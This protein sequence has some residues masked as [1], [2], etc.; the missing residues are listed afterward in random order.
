[1]KLKIRNILCAILMMF[2]VLLISSKSKAAETTVGG[3]TY[4]Y[5]VVNG[6][7]ENVWVSAGKD[8]FTGAIPG[9]IDGYTVVSIGD[10]TNNILGNRDYGHFDMTR[11]YLP[12]LDIVSKIEIPN[13]VTKI[14]KYAFYSV[15][16]R[17]AY[18]IPESV[19]TI[20]DYAFAESHCYDTDM[21]LVIPNSVQTIGDSAFSNRVS[22]E[23]VA[24]A[25][26]RPYDPDSAATGAYLKS[27]ADKLVLGSGL[28]TIGAN[29]FSYQKGLTGELVIPSNVTT[30]GTDAFRKTS[31]S[32]LTFQDRSSNVNVGESAFQSSVLT[33][34]NLKDKVVLDRNVFK[35]CVQLEDVNV[36]NTFTTI[37]E[38]AFTGCNSL[39][40][41]EVNSIIANAN[42]IGKS[43]FSYCDG[44][45][46]EI[47]IP[48]SLSSMDTGVFRE[49]SNLTS[50]KF[51]NSSLVIIPDS[52]FF[53][54]TS[55]SNIT[56]GSNIIGIGENAFEG[57]TSLSTAEVNDILT[58][59][60]SIGE[61]AF[62]GC[63]GI[64]GKINIRAEDVSSYAFSDCKNMTEAEFFY[65]RDTLDLGGGTFNNCESLV[66]VIFPEDKKIDIGSSS[67]FNNCKSLT[68]EKVKYIL[69]NT[70]GSVGNSCFM[71]CTGI[72]G[73][74][75]IPANITRIYDRAFYNDTGVTKIVFDDI[76]SRTSSLELGEKA[77]GNIATEQEVIYLPKMEGSWYSA[78][79]VGSNTFSNI[80][81]AY[82][83]MNEII[84]GDTIPYPSVRWWGT[85]GNKAYIHYNDCKHRI[86]ITSSLPGVTLVNPD[87]DEVLSSGSVPCGNEYKFK[88]VVDEAYAD[89]YPDLTIKIVSDG[90]YMNSDPVEEII[91]LE[92]GQTYTF[93]S[94]TRAK[95]IIV[96]AKSEGT[97]LVLRQFISTLN[98][99]NIRPTRAP[100][101]MVESNKAISYRHTKYPIIVK[102]DDKIVY[103][104]RVYNEGA[105]EGKA[106]EISVS[107]P[108]GLTFKANDEINTTYGWT[109]SDDGKTISTRYLENES[110]AAYRG[111]GRPNYKEV[112]YAL[113]VA[114][115][116]DTD[117]YMA[118]LAEITEGNDVDTAEGTTISRSLDNLMYDESMA[119]ST[120]SYIHFAEDD[121][122]YE[123]VLIE[124]KAST[125][126]S[127]VINKID[128]K[129]DELLNGA[130]FELL[131][132]DN[133]VI[134]S[135]VTTDG[136]IDFGSII[137]YGEGT[138]TYY[139]REVETPVGYRKTINGLMEISIVKT[140]NTSG[141]LE[142]TI[143]YD[144]DE[145]ED[146]DSVNDG[147]DEDEEVIPVSNQLELSQI[148]TD[149]EHTIDGTTYTF[150]KDAHYKLVNDITITGENWSGIEDF[151]GILD[152]DEHTISGLKINVNN[153]E[154][155]GLFKQCSGS[156]IDLTI[157]NAKITGTTNAESPKIGVFVGYMTEGSLINCHLTNSSIETNVQNVGGLIGHTKDLVK[158]SGC[159]T[160]EN[161]TI[162]AKYNIGGLVGCSVNQIDID[163]C[164]NAADITG[165]D[166]NVGGIVGFADKAIN[167]KKTNNSGNITSVEIST[168]VTETRPYPTMPNYVVQTTDYVG[169]T[170]IGGI[171]GYVNSSSVINATECTNTG[172]IYGLTNIGGIVGYSEAVTNMTLCT[173]DGEVTAKKHNVGGIV[174]HVEPKGEASA[175]TVVDMDEN[176]VINLYIRNK[177]T[178]GKYV[179]N[180]FALDAASNEKV[181]L[182]GA[183]FSIYGA[184]KE[185]IVEN[186]TVDANGNIKIDN[187]ILNSLV[188]DV[189]FIKETEAPEGY[190]VLV[191]DYIMLEVK[192]T[193]NAET[194]K[195]EISG[196]SQ[197]VTSMDDVTLSENVIANA[198]GEEIPNEAGSGRTANTND[199]E[200]P[201]T[202]T[203]YYKST[204]AV[205]ESCT[206]NGKIEGQNELTGVNGGSTAGGIVGLARGFVEVYNSNNT[207]EI[208]TPSNQ[209]Y[210]LTN[211]GGIVG[212]M[213]IIL[214][215]NESI[216]SGCTN[217]GNVTSANAGGIVGVTGSKIFVENCENTGTISTTYGNVGGI[218]GQAL[219]H[220]TLYGCTNKAI[221]TGGASGYTAGGLIG[222]DGYSMGGYDINTLGFFIRN[223]YLCIEGCTV[224]NTEVT[225]FKVGGLVGDMT[226]T[227]NF[228]YGCTVSDSTFDSPN[229]GDAS[230]CVGTFNGAEI[231]VEDTTVQDCTVSA[232]A[233]AAGVVAGQY[234]WHGNGSSNDS[235]WDRQIY[236]YHNV[237]VLGSTISGKDASG[238]MSQYLSYSTNADTVEFEF[239]DCYVGASENNNK[240]IITETSGTGN[241]AAG[242]FSNLYGYEIDD[243]KTSFENCTV[244]NTEI[245]DDDECGGIFGFVWEIDG[246][247]TFTNCKV[248]S[249]KITTT[250]RGIGGL[251]QGTYDCNS[252]PATIEVDNCLV[253][254]CVF[255]A[256]SGNVGGFIGEGY[257]RGAMKR[258]TNSTIRNTSITGGEN[259]G[260]LIG[261]MYSCNCEL[262]NC[263]VEG[264]DINNASHASFG[265]GEYSDY[266]QW[267]LPRTPFVCKNVKIRPYTRADNTVKKCTIT[268]EDYSFSMGG[269]IGSSYALPSIEFEDIEISGAEF[270]GKSV[271][272]GSLAGSICCTNPVEYALIKN[273][274]ISDIKL[275]NQG[276]GGS[277]VGGAFGLFNVTNPN[278]TTLEGININNVNIVH[279]NGKVGGFIGNGYL[280]SID[281]TARD[282]NLTD[283]NINVD[284]DYFEA[285]I[286]MGNAYRSGNSP[287]FED[288]K[289]EDCNLIVTGA[290]LRGYATAAAFIGSISYSTDISDIKIINS[291]VEVKETETE[292]PQH[293]AGI[294]AGPY[295]IHNISNI[296]I[297]G[298]TLINESKAKDS[299]TGGIFGYGYI[300][301]NI[302]TPVEISD[303]EINNLKITAYGG[304]VGG[305]YGGGLINVSNVTITNPI[306]KGLGDFSC[307]GGI[308]G[309]I[310]DAN[311]ITGVTVTADNTTSKIYS[312]Y[313][314]SG[315]AA[316]DNGFIKDSA[317]SNITVQSPMGEEESTETGDDD[318]VDVIN[319]G[320]AGAA[321]AIHSLY[322]N[323]AEN[324]TAENVT[325]V[326]SAE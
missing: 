37:P 212:D 141:E 189:F 39:T 323:D 272:M 293:V 305:V 278:D 56:I 78:I 260:A 216:V 57:C 143:Y 167:V 88:L 290:P 284:N 192:K 22:V 285:A 36:P 317:V 94:V 164:S 137:T 325:V 52:T 33:E 178:Q 171:V 225:G 242:M 98:G 119:S 151:T 213:S 239:A 71:N 227:E 47:V 326:H 129:T 145:I 231:L 235:N 244:E 294:I 62:S 153:N 110:I 220:T 253:E 113:V 103:A 215:A 17:Q 149:A 144:L 76:D 263:T 223:E 161:T 132:K 197:V 259:T 40:S 121:T 255:T 117:L 297:D 209:Y 100:N 311:T 115:G 91:D 46:D 298:L 187:N 210:P 268:N 23:L 86:D 182:A 13:T 42:S 83:N 257:D 301:E 176:H 205:F 185:A 108:D 243:T 136:K 314:A 211:A 194:E 304:G 127:L 191:K 251:M 125:E 139:L 163:N 279:S 44:L 249:C 93:D 306:I 214:L 218:I 14:N 207:A 264:V 154:K 60:Q 313:I 193:W 307:V 142:I 240:T 107:I 238:I 61:K 116:S 104:V 73:E 206:N 321:S 105:T 12:Q 288:I 147:V 77:F 25:Q 315:I 85:S 11:I 84:D 198:N 252:R 68:M 312:N 169:C 66:N 299:M 34:V 203:I 50:A 55:L 219:H 275:D 123:D 27:V 48:S 266:E 160:D 157:N 38:G 63:T 79:K 15:G 241:H 90:E 302:S 101:A 69:D 195:Y 162:K 45:V 174:G 177:S 92:P 281:T 183:K 237:K 43:A 148:G 32:K 303:S 75:H 202:Q 316:V 133:E 2:I 196:V 199:N 228:I 221:I 16:S 156:I 126:Y 146:E 26:Q 7:A 166:Y 179:L 277:N 175:Q 70:S 282:I 180:V 111:S 120:T 99:K 172:D 250:G 310:V 186:Q 24:S 89:R 131:N 130:K 114:D 322:V 158:L 224:S 289:I 59:I 248:K 246:P 159:S 102:K 190:E 287:K 274:D 318:V 135:A 258:I 232:K 65:N 295:Y 271:H 229:S 230:A 292:R 165:S 319:M 10:G 19:V 49:C 3:V 29:A 201:Q 95:K 261:Y 20:D 247:F 118:T 273:I 128:A 64:N 35:N 173:N 30:I 152:G 74:L 217:S 236:K 54:C 324:C 265:I 1:M 200:E 168:V 21:T 286:F 124:A 188:S 140:L 28:K 53:N 41:S 276:T 51:E 31:L 4:T 80:K 262:E 309:I 222:A 150:S 97:D 308:A 109:L 5:D 267:G 269:I 280:Q 234:G 106:N 300:G 81:D 184:N 87:T 233:T 9:T 122:D 138:D 6:K 134:K 112:E 155:A 254:D 181:K 245:Y 256:A 170:N 96:Q 8:N 18:T 320:G 72:E 296:T 226:S 67:T 208:K 82:V 270:T 283:I 58:N 291:K 204:K